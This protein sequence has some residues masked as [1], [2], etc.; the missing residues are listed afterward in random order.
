M[1]NHAI[2]EIPLIDHDLR[3]MSDEWVSSP[4]QKEVLLVRALAELRKSR[5]RHNQMPS[6][7]SKP[8]SSR[9][10]WESTRSDTTA[11][12]PS[13][14]ASMATGAAKPAGTAKP[15]TAPQAPSGKS[16]ARK[17]GKQPGAKG[18]GRTH[19]LA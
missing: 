16:T 2:K 6:N 12:A 15:A 9:A 19:K 7:S 1:L 3:Q 13:S 8:P 11:E 17:A 5:D 18:F 10:P 14:E 4:S